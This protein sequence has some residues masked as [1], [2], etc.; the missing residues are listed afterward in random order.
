MIVYYFFAITLIFLGY[1]SLKSGIEFYNYF[2]SEIAQ[3]KSEFTPFV[4]IIAPFC[5]F[6]EDIDKNIAALF[7]QVF[8]DYEIIF[9]L[10]SREDAALEF[11]ENA[12]RLF[13]KQKKIETKIIFAGKAADCGQKVHNLRIAIQLTSVKSKIFVFVDSD[14]TTEKEWL[15]NLIEPLK[16]E[17]IGVS[18][19]YRWFISKKNN[20]SSQFKTVWNASIASQL[21][22][23]TK[24][25]FCWGGSM[26]IQRKTFENLRLD[27]LWAGSLSDDFTLTNACKKA[28]LPIYFAPKCLTASISDCDFGDLLEFTTRQMKITRV[29]APN[30]WKASLIS[31]FLFSIIF[32]SGFLLLFVTFGLEFWLIVI[33]QFCII[34]L[35][36]WKAA[37]RLSAVRLILKNYE[38]ELKHSQLSHLTLWMF[39]P[40]IFLYNS[41]VALFSQKIAWRGIKYKLKSPT[42]TQIL[43]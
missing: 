15:L 26:A 7:N 13:G 27:E 11:I 28:K 3:P 30:L 25:N 21:G 16:D 6:D 31:S 33:I 8:P 22:K 43:R 2:Q 35:G 9:V 38:T 1:K 18:T 10:E 24:N 14:A 29:Y 4:S 23:E 37:I 12:I 34:F 36:T 39:T 42:E 32:W 19:G 20:L 17:N 41:I 40:M 5:G